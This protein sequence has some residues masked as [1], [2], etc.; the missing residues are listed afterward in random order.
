MRVEAVQLRRPRLGQVH[1]DDVEVAAGGL[2]IEPAV[3]VVYVDPRIGGRGVP[4]RGEV[5]SR[6]ADQRRIEL[7]IIDALQRAV[8]QSLRETAVDSAADEQQAA[9]RGMLEQGVVDRLLG[10][11]RIRNGRHRD[12]ALVDR[13]APFARDHRQVAVDRVLAPDQAEAAPQPIE[14]GALQACDDRSRKSERRQHRDRRGEPHSRTAQEQ[15]RRRDQVRGRHQEGD[16]ECAGMA[17]QHDARE[18]AARRGAGRFEQVH[19]AGGFARGGA[20]FSAVKAAGRG[21]QAARQHTERAQR[22]EADRQH[23]TRSQGFPRCRCDEF[24]AGADGVDR[25]RKYRRHQHE[26]RQR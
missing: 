5:L 3:Q 4:L 16:L 10:R 13:A 6:H 26:Q 18:Q 7:H 19:R 14:R 24:P 9:R 25:R 15:C 2:Q 22:D 1:D 20:G 12:A 23:C 21:E 8:P 17:Q 11:G